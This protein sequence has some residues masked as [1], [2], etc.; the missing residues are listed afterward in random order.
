MWIEWFCCTSQAKE[1]RSRVVKP[2]RNGI[3]HPHQLRYDTAL[4]EISDRGKIIHCIDMAIERSDT[5]HSCVRWSRRTLSPEKRGRVDTVASFRMWRPSSGVGVRILH[6][7]NLQ[8]WHPRATGRENRCVMT[9][10]RWRCVEFKEGRRAQISRAFKPK[11]SLQLI[12]PRSGQ[13]YFRYRE[14][15][16]HF[17]SSFQ[18]PLDFDLESFWYQVVHMFR[19]VAVTIA[20]G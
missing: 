20:F 19:S 10:C 13:S 4:H 7:F 8:R 15:M 11:I 1:P 9:C 18:V 16:A 2:I 5:L 17:T 14:Y 6:Y 3:F 12:R